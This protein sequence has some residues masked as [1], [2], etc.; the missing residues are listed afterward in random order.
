VPRQIFPTEDYLIAYYEYLSGNKGI[1]FLYLNS[2]EEEDEIHEKVFKL[3]D[4]ELADYSPS[5]ETLQSLVTPVWEI[6]ISGRLGFLGIYLPASR[7]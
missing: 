6:V 5:Q 4:L 7:F 3:E 2:D 1:I